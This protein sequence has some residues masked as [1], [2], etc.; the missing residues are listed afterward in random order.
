[1]LVII[2]III[3]QKHTR[4]FLAQRLLQRMQSQEDAA[5]CVQRV[6]RG[7]QVRRWYL[8]YRET[9]LILQRN[10]RAYLMRHR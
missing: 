1:M 7:W 2:I 8:A 6:Y 5:V 9:V 10:I 4:R 3:L